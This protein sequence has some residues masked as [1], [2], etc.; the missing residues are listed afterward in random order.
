MKIFIVWLVA[1]SLIGCKATYIK[2]ERG[3]ISYHVANC[4]AGMLMNNDYVN[5][6][7]ENRNPL[8]CDGYIELTAA[9]RKEY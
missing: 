5:M 1:L 3:L 6:L 4:L 8:T 2:T 9:E 7:D